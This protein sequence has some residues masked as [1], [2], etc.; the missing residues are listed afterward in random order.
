MGAEGPE[1]QTK[2]NKVTEL[3]ISLLKETPQ[4]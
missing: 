2:R 4:K 1:K 3:V